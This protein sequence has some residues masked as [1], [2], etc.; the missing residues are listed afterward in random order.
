MAR[1]IDDHIAALRG[2]EP[3]LGRIDG[4]ALVALHLQAVEQEGEFE[5]EPPLGRLG[6]QLL[7]AAFRQAAGI[8]QQ[9]A[10]QGGFAVIDMPDHDDR[11]GTLV[12]HM[13][14]M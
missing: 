1:R 2:A 3:D 5:I 14:Y 13:H 9:P 6:A 12:L 10:D 7:R 4:D 11:K 8:V